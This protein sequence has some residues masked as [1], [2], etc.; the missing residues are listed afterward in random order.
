[1]KREWKELMSASESLLKFSSDQFELDSVTS[2]MKQLS[3]AS[4]VALNL[5][6][7]KTGELKTA[8]FIGFP[9]AMEGISKLLDY[10]L[11]NNKWSPDP[12]RMTIIK[13]NKVTRYKRLTDFIQNT[14]SKESVKKLQKELNIGNT[15]VIRISKED[16]LIGDFTLLFKK[17][18]RLKN[19]DSVVVY[20]EFV[21]LFLD[22]QKAEEK[23]EK[24]RH[25][26]RTIIDSVPSMIFVKNAEGKFLEA[27]K[28]VANRLR[29]MT[30]EIVGKRHSE[31]HP[32]LEEVKGM[33]E[34]DRKI[35]SGEMSRFVNN[36]TYY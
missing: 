19:K 21:G 35:L 4:Y 20:A 32:D 25:R 30:S 17:G 33:L 36:E 14:V 27:N 2:S 7:E 16:R 28:A 18:N 9:G 13:N 11:K 10:D 6:D 15:Y 12:D 24:N 26:L 5:F 1:M 22:K 29:L 34:E 3:K 31:I 23:V 8:S